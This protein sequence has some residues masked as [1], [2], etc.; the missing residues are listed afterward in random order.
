MKNLITHINQ[1]TTFGLEK[2]TE[3]AN[4]TTLKQMLVAIYTEYLSAEVVFEDNAAEAPDV[5]YKAI[6]RNVESNFPKFGFYN[7]VLEDESI[8]IGD[9]I[10]DLTDIIKD[11]LTVQWYFENTT[12]TNALWH[13]KFLMQSHSEQHLVDLLKYLTDNGH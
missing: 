9:A 13:F 10:D 8:G 3:K 4:T 2:L 7:T 5:D 6:R 11:L 12:E 1:L